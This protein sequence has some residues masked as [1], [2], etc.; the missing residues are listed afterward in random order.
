MRRFLIAL[1]L[2]VLLVISIGVGVLIADWPHWSHKL[3]ANVELSPIAT[4]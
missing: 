2:I 4:R 3:A 1:V